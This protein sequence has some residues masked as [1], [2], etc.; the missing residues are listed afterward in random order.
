MPFWCACLADQGQLDTVRF[1]DVFFF[2]RIRMQLLWQVLAAI[3]NIETSLLLS[4]TSGTD[5]QNLGNK[6][7][8][9]RREH[10]SALAGKLL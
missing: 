4:V 5:S 2:T 3:R 1:D 6:E 8:T 10:T 9:G 7:N